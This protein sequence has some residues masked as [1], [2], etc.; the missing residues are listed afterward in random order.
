[1]NINDVARIWL[2]TYSNGRTATSLRYLQW[3]R[4]S[5]DLAPNPGQLDASRKAYYADLCKHQALFTELLK[6]ICWD[7]LVESP[8]SRPHAWQFAQAARAVRRAED[9]LI[10]KREWISAAEGASAEQLETAFTFDSVVDFKAVGSVLIVD[11]VL[12]EGKTATAI[13]LK[14]QKFGLRPDAAITLAV[15]LRVLPQQP[16]KRFGMAAIKSIMQ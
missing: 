13:V 14:L 8:S 1:M 3:L 12:A 7:L 6:P 15:A 4:S 11:D 10:Q 5:P 9:I 16:Q 2:D